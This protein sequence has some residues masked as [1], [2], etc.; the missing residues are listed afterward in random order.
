MSA[1]WETGRVDTFLLGLVLYSPPV[2][3]CSRKE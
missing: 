3:I 2:G 1:A